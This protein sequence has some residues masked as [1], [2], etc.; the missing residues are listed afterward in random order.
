VLAVDVIVKSFVGE[1]DEVGKRHK[2]LKWIAS[3]KSLPATGWAS[4]HHY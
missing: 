3:K 4:K 1:Q 2:I